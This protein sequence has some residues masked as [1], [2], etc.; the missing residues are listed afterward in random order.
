MGLILD[1]NLDLVIQIFEYIRGIRPKLLFVFFVLPIFLLKA[2]PSSIS[3]VL[4]IVYYALVNLWFLTIVIFSGL[5]VKKIK[6]SVLAITLLLVINICI[7]LFTDVKLFDNYAKYSG[8]SFIPFLLSQF[9][10]AFLTSQSIKHLIIKPKNIRDFKINHLFD[11]MYV[12]FLIL[13]Y[14]VGV[15][16]IQKLLQKHRQ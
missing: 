14:P 1:I 3:E 7:L 2:F 8:Y 12:F 6:K 4:S 11:S 16:V 9:V 5:N 13:W 15:F 10:I